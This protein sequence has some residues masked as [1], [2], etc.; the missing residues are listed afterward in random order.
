MHRY[1]SWLKQEM[2]ADI[3]DVHTDSTI[4]LLIAAD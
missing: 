2:A 4:D 1:P 3:E